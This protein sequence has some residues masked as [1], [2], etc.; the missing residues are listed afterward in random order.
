M[1]GTIGCTKIRC[2]I[3]I[4]WNRCSWSIDFCDI[5]LRKTGK[6]NQSKLSISK[7]LL[8][9]IV[10]FQLVVYQY[11]HQWLESVVWHLVHRRI[12]D[13]LEKQV[14]FSLDPLWKTK[15]KMNISTFVSIFT[16]LSVVFL[17]HFDNS[18]F[19]LEIFSNVE[20]AA[21]NCTVYS[22][23]RHC[24]WNYSM[25]KNKKHKQSIRKKYRVEIKPKC[26]RI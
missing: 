20:L 9:Q 13:F 5:S 7:S 19:V 21:M 18:E 2:R 10:W 16:W 11:V 1:I 23:I 22:P 24:H 26:T 15:I 4:D 25:A 14:S 12:S 6:I 3:V 17:I 8:L